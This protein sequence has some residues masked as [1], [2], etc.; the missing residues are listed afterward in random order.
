MSQFELRYRK[1]DIE[2]AVE[3][4]NLKK[5][6]IR[7]A[8]T[9]EDL[10]QV[11]GAGRDWK[12]AD[13]GQFQE[14]TLFKKVKK[15]DTIKHHDQGKF[16]NFSNG[17]LVIRNGKGNVSEIIPKGKTNQKSI[18]PGYKGFE[19]GRHYEFASQ[20]QTGA[21]LHRD[22]FGEHP[23]Y[24]TESGEV[25]VFKSTDKYGDKYTQFFKNLKGILKEIDNDR[26]PGLDGR[27]LKYLSSS[28][29]S[30][31]SAKRK[32]ALHKLIQEHFRFDESTDAIEKWAVFHTLLRPEV[33]RNVLLGYPVTGG[34]SKKMA[35]E[36]K[37]TMHDFGRTEQLVW[38]YLKDVADTSHDRY[39]DSGISAKEADQFGKNIITELKIAAARKGLP[40][41]DMRLAHDGFYSEPLDLSKHYL[42]SDIYLNQSVYDKTKV[43]SDAVR[44]F[45]DV[46]VRYAQ[47]E[48]GLIDPFTLYKAQKELT[49]DV[50]GTKGIPMNETFMSISWE[51][52]SRAFGSPLSKGFKTWN[53][54]GRFWGGSGLVTEKPLKY[55]E[56]VTRCLKP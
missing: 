32:R 46:L 19:H 28:E 31:H 12:Y 44:A 4:Q 18:Y 21:H 55:L 10:R 37:V 45:A 14:Y 9:A 16:T 5:Q 38:E 7:L 29:Q 1:M 3:Y 35:F 56:D 42:Y 51:K 15:G 41:A 47:G 22:A 40:Y 36:D 2:Q 17:A 20:D 6:K 11:M 25:I 52:P 27:S 30:A 13:E 49:R 33:N 23:A 39:K 26:Y 48:G 34:S 50:A 43:G 53:T 24:R 8:E 54:K